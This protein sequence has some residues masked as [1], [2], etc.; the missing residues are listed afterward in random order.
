[1]KTGSTLVHMTALVACFAAH[2]VFAPELN[3]VRRALETVAGSNGHTKSEVPLAVFPID[4]A[5]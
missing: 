3:G 4:N 1:M 5:L 2:L